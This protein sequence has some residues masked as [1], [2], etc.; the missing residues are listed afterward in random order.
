MAFFT[1]GVQ[2]QT[3]INALPASKKGS[4]EIFNA[5]SYGQK[6][7]LGYSGLLSP[8]EHFVQIGADRGFAPSDSFDPVFYKNKFA[9][10]KDTNL[11]AADLLIH[12]L[13]FGLDEGRVPN[14]SLNSFNATAY[15]AANA[16]VT[17]ALTPAVLARDFG[18]SLASG[19]LAHYVKFGQAEGRP[20]GTPTGS[21]VTQSLT[22]QPGTDVFN[23][24]SA[25]DVV[26]GV[27]GTA[28]GTQDQ[29][30][31]N[32]SDVLNGGGGNNTLA[33][34]LNGNYGG[35]ATIKDFQ[36]LQIGSNVQGAVVF[37]YN[38]NAGAFEITGTNTIVADQ[39]NVG[40][41]LTVNNI[42][43]TVVGEARILPTLSWANDSNTAL[44][45]TVNYNYRA[46]EL[47][48]TAD[49]QI[50]SLNKVNNGVLNLA[51]GIETVTLRSVAGERVTLLNSTTADTGTGN[52]N[53]AADIISN[54][55]LTRV[56]IEAAAEVGKVGGRVAATGLVDNA[57][58]T[59]LASTGAG[60]NLLS[61]G[62][63]VTTVDANTST[64]NVNVQFLAKTDGAATNV[65]VIGG[66]GNDYV[67]FEIGNVNAT[68]GAGN[69]TFAFVTQ[70]NG[71]TNSTFGAGDT[72]VGGAGTDTIQMGVNGVGNYTISDSEWANKSGI[73]TLDLR[74]AVNTV[75]LSSAFVAAADT[76]VKLTVTT[77][78]TVV[79]ATATSNNEYVQVN[80]IDLRV[81]SGGQGINFVGGQG[82]DRLILSDS[83]FTSAMT[84]N[85]GSNVSAAGNAAAGDYDTLTVS[86]SAVLDR[87]DL[88]NVSGFEGLVLNKTVTGA[89][90][91]VIELSEAFVLANTVAINNALTSIA[92]NVFQ[93]GTAA[94]ANGTALVAGDVVRIDVTDLFTTNNNTI[95]ASVAARQI[96]TTTLTNAGVTV[97]YVY[98]GTTY[99]TLAALNA[100][101]VANTVLAGADAAGQTGVVGAGAA[102]GTP[103]T[104]ITFTSSAVGAT[105]GVLGTNNNDVFTL[106]QADTVNGGT[107]SDTVNL[108]A[109]SATAVVTLGTGADTININTVI[110][111]TGAAVVITAASSTVNI[112]V[113]Q[114]GAADLT[115][116]ITGAFAHTYNVSAAQAGL[117]V[118]N[119]A[120]ATINAS[121]GGTFSL[122]AA[123]QIFTSS[124]TNNVVVIGGGAGDTITLANTGTGIVTAG[125]GIDAI[126]ITG[127]TGVTTI[128]VAA[129]AAD[130]DTVTGFSAA[131]D[132]IALSAAATTAGTAAAATPVIQAVVAAGATLLSN[133]ADVTVFNFDMGGATNVLGGVLDG[134]ALTANTGALTVAGAGD[135]G[136]IVAYDA[137][138]AFVYSYNSGADTNV[139]ANEVALVG[140]FNGVA[141]GALGV[142]NFAL[143]A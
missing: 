101:V 100:V 95:K 31:L 118:L 136:Y 82:S 42:V 102:L 33:V 133:A 47:T 78:A 40:E 50:V 39:I 57:A 66:A 86:N 123:G 30:T 80:T 142:A 116:E 122:G 56:N 135:I 115:A 15:L 41:T 130:R 88:A 83:T 46:A 28:L 48:G 45:G 60:E 22:L 13:R 140:T 124:G 92:D 16:D 25:N 91:T 65:T 6:Y 97:N 138:A 94:G 55:S 113:D 69:D 54:G 4:F 119:T 5:F 112:T 14:S 35:G 68:G 141:V 107:G 103:N 18:G 10:L 120:G 52:N 72:I 53:V 44:A 74:G 76:G 139:T 70:R 49:T 38:V 8:L 75:T 93:I 58:Q 59:G 132:I 114:G 63:R 43:R 17:A 96:D 143:I 27:A 62:A 111:A 21:G 131:N 29:T 87:T 12:F 134:A 84:L 127:A 64:A 19:A 125:G 2:L 99:A 137:G 32:S 77:D 89:T 1:T 24:T 11:N 51:A 85:G 23:G 108:N 71:V 67:E 3:A 61:V 104:G 106:T 110:A 105:A 126:T 73:E 81:L 7:L 26:R 90:T 109:G 79:G 20:A 128:V 9:D 37:D 129:A 36:T 34:L 117:T 121:A 98:N